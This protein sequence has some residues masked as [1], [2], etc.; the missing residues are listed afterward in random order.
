MQNNIPYRDAFLDDM[1]VKFSEFKA[2]I[3]FIEY[4]INKYRIY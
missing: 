3:T 2:E 4:K 1:N